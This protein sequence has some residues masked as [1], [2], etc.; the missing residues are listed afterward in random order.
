MQFQVI[1]DIFCLFSSLALDLI[2]SALSFFKSNFINRDTAFLY[3]PLSD[4]LLVCFNSIFFFLILYSQK[5]NSFTLLLDG[6]ACL[7]TK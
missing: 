6:Y 3:V 7:Q 1:E 5:T 2:G 4:F